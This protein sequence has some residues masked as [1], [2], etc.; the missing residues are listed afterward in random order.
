[1]VQ[2]NAKADSLTG[3]RLPWADRF[4]KPDLKQLHAH[5]D[6]PASQLFESA[7]ESVARSEAVQERLA[8]QGLPWRWTLVFEH[9]ADPTRALAYLVPDPQSVKISVPLTTEMIQRLPLRRMKKTI[10]D[11][12]EAGNRIA[13]VVW[14]CWDVGSENQLEEIIDIVNTKLAYIEEHA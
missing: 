3:E 9:P 2:I 12:I 7:R 4:A 11:G 10:R 5:Y 6:Q 1:M 8:W 14:A 13:S